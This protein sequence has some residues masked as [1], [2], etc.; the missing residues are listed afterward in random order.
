[1]KGHA[2]QSLACLKLSSSMARTCIHNPQ[3]GKPRTPLLGNRLLS[4]GA[5]TSFKP[6]QQAGERAST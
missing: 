4:P 3:C 5:A 6:L 1:M 2:P